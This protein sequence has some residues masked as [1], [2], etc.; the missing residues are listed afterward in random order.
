MVKRFGIIGVVAVLLWGAVSCADKYEVSYSERE[1][2]SLDAWVAKHI[3]TPTERAVRLD[4]GMWVEITDLGNTD[5]IAT[6]D[7]SLWVKYNFTVRDLGGNVS[8]SRLE[9]V[10]RWQGTYTRY[11]HYV[12][13]Y[14]FCG[15]YNSNLL[16]GTYYIM[17]NTLKDVAGNDVNLHVGTKGT[18]YMPSSL[19][20]GAYGTSNDAGYG[21][22]FSLD[23]NIPA[24]LDFEIT[25]ITKDPVKTEEAEVDAYIAGD[26]SWQLVSD[27]LKYLYVDKRYRLPEG[28][29]AYKGD[30]IL[31]DSTVKIWYVGRFLDGFVFD[32]NIDSVKR[33][34]YGEVLTEGEA[35]EFTPP[36]GDESVSIDSSTGTASGSSFI[37]AWNYTI[38]TLLQGQWARIICTSAYGYEGYGQ[39]RNGSTSTSGSSSDYFYYDYY[40]WYNNPYTSYY[41]GYYNSYYNSYYDYYNYY[42]YY[43][44]STSTDE[45]ESTT[46]VYTEIQSYTPLIFEIHIEE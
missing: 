39:Y 18:I 7:T 31:Q 24:I 17:R 14:I 43:N 2:L 4:N 46:T 28:E 10:A 40:N 11:T 23:G 30:S 22:Q 1:Q 45:S 8:F 32:T 5:E 27:T 20:Y 6:R 33:R 37:N 25:Y 26:D 38:P 29:E 44:T 34:V 41:S 9:D 16:E 15:D 19:A 13:D 42:N 3:N 21:G 12:P 35:M 36:T